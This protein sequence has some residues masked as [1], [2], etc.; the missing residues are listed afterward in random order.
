MGGGASKPLRMRRAESVR[1]YV[2]DLGSAYSD[3]AKKLHENGYDGDVL[4]SMSEDE[5]AEL[6]D[7]LEVP[8]P[9]RIVLRRK[10]SG[11]KGARGVQ[12]PESGGEQV[13]EILA[14]RRREAVY[15]G[16][17]GA[18]HLERPGTNDGRNA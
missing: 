11:L 8:K 12:P 16:L 9:Q 2:E 14:R 1:H 7:E 10:L 4:A 6:F 18:L 17:G 15:E 3:F 13:D 5:L